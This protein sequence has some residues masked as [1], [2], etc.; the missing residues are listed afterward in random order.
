MTTHHSTELERLCHQRTCPDCGTVLT[1][2]GSMQT[3]DYCE[4]VAFC[5]ECQTHQDFFM[6]D[7]EAL[8]VH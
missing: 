5:P 7:G 3:V 8:S 4:V 6:Q 2:G 1:Y